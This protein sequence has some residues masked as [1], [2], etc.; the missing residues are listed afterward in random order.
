MKFLFILFILLGYG[1]PV[2]TVEATTQSSTKTKK[3]PT[4][5]H[6]SY[7]ITTGIGLGELKETVD[8]S[9]K[10][11]TH[12]FNISSN[13]QATGIFKVIK[14]GNILRNS[15]GIVTEKG[16]QPSY[17]SDQR[18]TRAPSLAIFDWENKIL[19]LKHKGREK[20]EPLVAGTLDRLSLSYHFIFLPQIENL[21]EAQLGKLLD[22]PV[23]DGRNL[24]LMQ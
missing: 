4:R 1:I 23:T 15:R 19:T 24:Q 11:E 9:Q 20:Q 21:A 6:I 22:I 12:T 8:I 13:A 7:T 14:P 3:L 16:L 17:Y 10:N 18:G 2:L 5:I